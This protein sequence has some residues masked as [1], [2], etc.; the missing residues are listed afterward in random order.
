MLKT[1]QGGMDCEENEVYRVKNIRGRALVFYHNHPHC[2][3]KVEGKGKMLL[4]GECYLEE[5]VEEIVKKT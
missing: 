5:I 3:R 4:R 1:V 2:G